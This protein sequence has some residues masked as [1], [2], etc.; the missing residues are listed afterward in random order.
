[1]KARLIYAYEFFSLAEYHTDIFCYRSTDGNYL[2]LQ[3]QTFDIAHILIYYNSCELYQTFTLTGTSEKCQISILAVFSAVNIFLTCDRDKV[4][5]NHTKSN[6]VRNELQSQS[7][8]KSIYLMHFHTRSSS[9]DS[10][11]QYL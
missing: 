9:L 10:D 2:Y 11:A 1:M 8:M 3:V 5:Y 4:G 6:N 7:C